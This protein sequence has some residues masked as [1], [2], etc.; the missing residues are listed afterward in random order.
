[1]DYF[2]IALGGFL[3]GVYIQNLKDRKPPAARP[4]RRPMD[5]AERQLR[6]FLRG[7]DA[8]EKGVAAQLR[9]EQLEARRLPRRGSRIS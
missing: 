3:F 4:P 6:A 1:M 5:A 7:M 2:L 9:R 8:F